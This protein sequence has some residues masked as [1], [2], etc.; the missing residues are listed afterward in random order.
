[1]VN[2]PAS[3]ASGVVEDCAAMRFAGTAHGRHFPR[4]ESLTAVDGRAEIR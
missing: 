2:A 4:R 1:M 3:A